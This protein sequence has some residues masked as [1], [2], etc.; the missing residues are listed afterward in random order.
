MYV[1]TAAL[2]SAALTFL[3]RL[4]TSTVMTV[5]G[6]CRIQFIYIGTC[7]KFIMKNANIVGEKG[8]SHVVNACV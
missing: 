2:L 3:C 6:S 8:L 1:F 7:T 5:M 4:V